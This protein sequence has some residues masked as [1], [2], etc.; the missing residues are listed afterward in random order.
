MKYS[1]ATILF[2]VQGI[3]AAP[4][5]LSQLRHQTANPKVPSSGDDITSVTALLDIAAL[6]S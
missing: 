5:L 2:L 6:A 3:I 1:T 4:S